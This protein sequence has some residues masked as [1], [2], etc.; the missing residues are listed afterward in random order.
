VD[1]GLVL[2]TIAHV[3][4]LQQSAG[5]TFDALLQEYLRDKR[6]LLVLDN[7]EQIVTAAPPLAALHQQASGLTLLVTSRTLLR[8]RGEK[9]MAVPPLPLP[10]DA[11]QVA[12]VT[13]A[14]AVQ[15]FVARVQD[16][17]PGFRL[18]E[19]IA[20]TV[21][22]ICTQLDGLPLAL[23]LAAARA[24]LL[25]IQTLRQRLADPLA[26]LTH[27]AR[28]LPDRQQT[29]RA[30][31]AWS[32]AL[33]TPAEQTLFRRLA[34]FR[35]GFSLEAAQAVGN[36]GGDPQV[37]RL[38]EVASLIDQNL[39]QRETGQGGELRFTM[40]ETIREFGLERLTASGESESI[41][42]RHVDFFLAFSEAVEPEL[43]GPHRERW[44]ARLEA[45]HD[46]LRAAL[47]WSQ[48]HGDADEANL[49]LVG[50]LTW[51]W[52]FGNH[53]SE[54]RG[55]FASILNASS[56]PADSRGEPSAPGATAALSKA[57]WG[58]GLMALIES[59]YQDARNQLE[60]SV[61]IGRQ[62]ADPGGLAISL[63]ELGLVV[64]H[65]GDLAAAHR[66]CAESVALSREAGS[67]WDL[68][69]ALHNLAHVV[70]ALGDHATAHALFAE[71]LSLFQALQDNW[72]FANVLSGLGL[73][74]GQQ[75]DYESART[76]FEAALT[77][78]QGQV[79]KWSLAQTLN[80]LGEVAERQG[81]LE[82]ASDLYT[83][84]L[85]L[86]REVGDRG[87]MALVLHHLGAI[88]RFGEEYERAA[89]L[90]AAAAS[91]HMGGSGPSPLTL[92]DSTDLERDIAAVHAVLGE[93]AFAAAWEAG[94]RLSTQA[95]IELAL[96]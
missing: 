83:Q 96:R 64:Q 67:R 25:T 84:C 69:L 20:A 39:L 30:T 58:A 86:S 70:N 36:A 42:R 78:W 11:E 1:A 43:Q 54:A 18:A 8:L 61:A 74:A 4:G 13:E 29:L 31:I 66:Y 71:C 76:Q 2:P 10:N 94:C 33:L 68:A 89:T 14:E 28:D 37:D 65:Q 55:W 73:M 23:E 45:E 27:G 5:R 57:L 16:V 60:E 3:L 34:V 44:L 50:A 22:A 95:A 59:D 38:E 92:T 77:L 46:N 12:Q 41:R 7:F 17:Q 9:E 32:V 63:R 53:I 80:L 82:E 35:G 24:R 91:L 62:V 90:L 81:K 88:A 85:L 48:A 52:L 56:V 15:L 40:L 49:R 21:A 47:A 6:L 19:E 51:F 93:K 72:G 26:F 79:D 87:R 75:S